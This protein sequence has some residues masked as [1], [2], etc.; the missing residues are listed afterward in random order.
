M[1]IQIEDAP[2]SQK[3]LDVE[4]PNETFTKACDAECDKIAKTAK[5]HGFRPGKAPRDVVYR[6]YV[7]SIK[8]NALESV[9]NEALREAMVQNNITPLAQAEVKD[10]VLED[11]EPI[12]FS[13]YVDVY[14]SFEVPNY[15]GFSFDRTVLQVSDEDIEDTIRHM[16]EN[17][18]NYTAVEED[19]AVQDGDRVI[20][21]FEGKVDNVPFEGGKA[22]KYPLNIGS[23]QFIEGFEDQIIGMKPG[24]SKDITVT[25]PKEYHQE[26]LAG[27]ESVFSIVLH[28][29]QQKAEAKLDD[30]YAKK[31]N[32]KANSV[33]ELREIIKK[34]LQNEADNYVKYNALTDM[35]NKLIEENPFEVPQSIIAEQASG[36][37]QQHMQQYR[38]M[39]IDPSMFGITIDS[40]KANLMP[41]A[42]VQVKRALILN[43][44]AD[45]YNIEVSDSDVDGEIERIAAISGEDKDELKKQLEKKQQ[46]P[47]IKNNVLTDKVYAF[48]VENNSV[49]DRFLS[50]SELEKEKQAEEAKK[51]ENNSEK[52]D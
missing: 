21:D 26:S 25:F 19:R 50:L 39:G 33:A 52:N 24:E 6:Q 43:R 34:D 7:H 15:K 17:N 44:I 51:A 49:N 3:K 47:S 36:M 16:M 40:L 30:E 38:Q 35:L 23:K 2:K 11:G 27:K 9:I 31:M 10:V 4:I 8:A 22:E 48:L 37:A 13:A 20:I 46:L 1:N 42:E 12:T 29:I 5:I 45:T 28:E 18:E 32:S 14:P 41:D